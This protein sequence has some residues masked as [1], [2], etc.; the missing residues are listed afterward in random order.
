M[1]FS[2][3]IKRIL[4]LI[5]IVFSTISVSSAEIINQFKI[6]GNERIPNE[7][8]IMFSGVN[9]GENISATELNE[10]LKYLRL[11]FF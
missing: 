7:T 10:I 11:K 5:V 6:D 9:I 8:I 3:F 1:M 4:F 2:N